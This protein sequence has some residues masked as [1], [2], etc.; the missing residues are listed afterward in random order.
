MLWKPFSLAYFTL[1][2]WETN[3][4]FSLIHHGARLEIDHRGAYLLYPDLIPPSDR[5]QRTIRI[6]ILN[7]IAIHFNLIVLIALF[8]A[9]PRMSYPGKGK[10]VAVGIALIS[11]L[12][13]A[14][15]YYLSDLFIWNYV[16]RRRWPVG[17]SADQIPRLIENIERRFP[18]SARPWIL[19]LYSYWDHFLRES[20]P[21]LVWAYFAYPF[22]LP[23]KKEDVP[24]KSR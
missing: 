16:E 7:R 18:R 3:A 22:L 13:V 20:A 14:H 1:L 21:L 8:F 17:I 4:V 9:T 23:K 12:H 2:R 6:P 24:R 15:I 11:L 10:G 5:L 19:V